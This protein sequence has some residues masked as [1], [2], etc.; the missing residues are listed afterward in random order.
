MLTMTPPNS[1]KGVSQGGV[2]CLYQETI[3]S[4]AAS[5]R[6]D[7]PLKSYDFSIAKRSKLCGS[8][9]TL[10]ARL[11]E[12]H[13]IAEIGYKTKVCLLGMASTALVVTQA[14]GCSAQDLQ[15]VANQL[16]R[17]LAGE[18]D[19]V[20][21]SPWQDLSIFKAALAF[22]ERHSA[23]LLPFKALLEGFA[24]QKV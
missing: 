19:V 21:E 7:R 24:T 18:R 2:E 3:K 22:P 20:F 1:E 8:E 13:K 15:T 14:P 23:I 12:D 16:T 10:D 4:L 5:I 6:R 17:L 11:Q 9:V